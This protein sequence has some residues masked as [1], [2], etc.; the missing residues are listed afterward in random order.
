MMNKRLTGTGVAL[1]TPFDQIGDV[2]YEAL[3]RIVENVITSGV[4]FLVVFG[5]TGETPTLNDEEKC[6]ILKLVKRVNNG[7]LPIVIGMSG[8]DTCAL[9]KQ[10]RKFD[11]SGIDALLSASP[12]YNKPSQEGIYGHFKLVA[13]ASPVPVILYNVPGRTGSNMAPETV[14][15]LARHK[16][17]VA[18]K[19]ASGNMAQVS[20]ILRDKPEEFILL[21]GEDNLAVAT[22]ALGGEGIISV[23]ANAFPKR[24]SQMIH[25][26]M[27]G[28]FKT[29]SAIQLELFEMIELLFAEGNPVGV[30][31]ALAIQ[32]FCNQC[33]RLPLVPGS[34]ELKEKMQKIIA[35]KFAQ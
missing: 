7:R 30:K 19:E 14:V 31:I 13:D 29:A 25:S 26:A 3:K 12:Y 1:V 10:L 32:G 16:N 17:I 8:N 28:D 35:E 20:K 27:E 24:F 4:D 21:S 18:I 23:A 11:F 2:D 9:V 6:E 22:I 5:T 15:R 34:N 33:V